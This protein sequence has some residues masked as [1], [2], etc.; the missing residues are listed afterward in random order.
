[1]DILLALVLKMLPLYGIMAAGYVL[2]RKFPD[3]VA[4]TSTLQIF[5]I[6]PVVLAATIGGITFTPEYLVLPILFYILCCGVG[7]FTYRIAGGNDGS[8]NL[9]AFAC[10]SS[11]NGYFGL[12]IA[13]I[14]FPPELVGVFLLAG[15]GFIFYENTLGYYLIARGRFTA[16]EALA[17]LSKLPTLYG[18]LLGLLISALAITLPEPLTIAAGNFRGAYVVLGALIIGLGL[19]RAK[20]FEMDRR[21]LAIPLIMKFMVWPAL[22][23]GVAWVDAQYIHFFDANARSIIML[24]GLMPLPANAVAFALQLN[25]HPE[26]AALVVFLNTL[27]A[28][29]FIPV[30]LMLTGML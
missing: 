19:S 20:G 30:M 23:F 25:V 13:M 18:A 10:G 1:M 11:N 8:R 24:L 22:T 7:L 2:G 6:A 17:R 3:T 29:F 15:L 4:P 9:L 12:P 16:R 28:L 21:F 14:L 5:L 26:K 27:V